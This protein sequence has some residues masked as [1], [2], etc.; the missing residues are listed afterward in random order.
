MA[1]V[2]RR[3]NAFDVQ[4]MPELVRVKH[5]CDAHHEPML[6]DEVEVAPRAGKTK[7]HDP[8]ICSLHPSAGLV[9]SP[10]LETE[11]IQA[12]VDDLASRL[13]EREPKRAIGIRRC[14]END[15][16]STTSSTRFAADG[17]MP[18]CYFEQPLDLGIAYAW[19]ERLLT[20]PI[21]LQNS[22]KLFDGA[23]LQGR[24]RGP[25]QVPHH[26][27]CLACWRLACK[28]SLLD[29]LDNIP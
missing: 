12:P 5:F 17:A 20:A 3:S 2:Q 10:D 23:A 25:R 22:S 24:T 6:Q 7:R 29:A 1:V 16:A 4:A 15:T 11:A 21:V 19:M 8:L 18:V 28:V 26:A 9:D 27:E 13:A 14:Q